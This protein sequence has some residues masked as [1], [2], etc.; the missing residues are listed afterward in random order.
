MQKVRV[1][2]IVTVLKSSTQPSSTTI[3]KNNEY[4]YEILSRNFYF[5]SQWHS[6]GT[7]RL[8]GTNIVTLNQ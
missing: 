7:L 3:I 1:A 5:L 4:K 6:C 8:E 2:I